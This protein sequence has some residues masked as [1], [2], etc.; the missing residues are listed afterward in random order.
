MLP[1]SNFRSMPAHS[2]ISRGNTATKAVLTPLRRR[3][4]PDRRRSG[5]WWFQRLRCLC[6]GRSGDCRRCRW[7]GGR[8]R[9]GR[10]PAESS[11][12]SS[13][14]RRRRGRRRLSRSLCRRLCHRLLRPRLLG[15]GVRPLHHHRGDVGGLRRRGRRNG[16]RRGRRRGGRDS[17]GRRGGGGRV[18]AKHREAEY[19]RGDQ[20]G[21]SRKPE[22]DDRGTARRLSV[23]GLL[24]PEVQLRAGVGGPLDVL[25]IRVVRVDIF[26][27][28]QRAE[29][30]GRLARTHGSSRHRGARGRRH[31]GRCL[32]ET[33]AVMRS[34]THPRPR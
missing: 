13:R 1:A 14:S 22:Q 12:E 29:G 15:S 4:R 32:D 19:R 2:C 9:G 33:T 20:R 34:A 31:R 16:R 10:S 24:V 11:L 18:T 28:R 7:R 30:G 6:P 27:P 17:G 25:R 23:V 26:G 8:G 5:A 21:G 3:R